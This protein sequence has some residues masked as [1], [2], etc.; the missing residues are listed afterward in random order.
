MRTLVVSAA[1]EAYFPLLD[2][3]IGSLQ[4]W[5]ASPFT[6]LACF[7]VG[8]APS[9][10]AS[11]AQRVSRI[12]E[13]GWDLPVHPELRAELPAHRARTVRPFLPRYFPGYDVYIWIDADAWVQERFAIDWYVGAA[14]Q[15]L[16]G[17]VP[18]VHFAYRTTPGLLHWRTSRMQ[19]YFGQEAAAEIRW[20]V[21]LN[22]G[23]FALPSDAPHWEI[24]AKS[25]TRGLE[26]TNGRL[27]SDQTAL[28]HAVWTANL[29][30]SPLPAICN[31]LCHLAMPGFDSTHGKFCEPVAPTHVI[32][33]LH[34]TGHAR[35][36]R[37]D[38]HSADAFLRTMSL[39]FPG[40][41]RSTA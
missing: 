33:I 10:R 38:L 37:F 11:L 1:D 31:W 34:L 19:A 30:V 23:V 12:V 16:L 2:G 36:R 7:D 21:Y 15:G 9:S 4:Q 17:A 40:V 14:A 32:G 28:N 27:C 25:F 20:D 26:A 8:L 6:D 5:E 24:W 41:H 22:S 3:L 29:P 35:D 13:P 39:R 18:H